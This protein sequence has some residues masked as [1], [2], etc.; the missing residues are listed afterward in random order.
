MIDLRFR[1]LGGWF[2]IVVILFYN[3]G[4]WFWKFRGWGVGF[5]VLEELVI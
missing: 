1:S 3:I 5:L 4:Y 2:V